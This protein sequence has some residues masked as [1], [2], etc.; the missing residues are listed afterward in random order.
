M[1]RLRDGVVVDD[2][3]LGDGHPAEDVIRSVSQLG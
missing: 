3:A 1:I 2:L